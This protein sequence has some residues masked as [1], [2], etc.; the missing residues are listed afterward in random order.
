[1]ITLIYLS[2]ALHVH[3]L[4]RGNALTCRLMTLNWRLA[5]GRGATD[6]RP[7]HTRPSAAACG[8]WSLA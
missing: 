3:S 2:S 4:A 1:M 6:R 8:Q 5:V 7:P